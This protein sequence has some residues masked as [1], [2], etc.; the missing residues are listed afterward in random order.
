VFCDSQ[1]PTAE[2]L[3]LGDLRYG[4]GG[5]VG[6]CSSIKPLMMMQLKHWTDNEPLRY[7]QLAQSTKAV[8]NR[9]SMQGAKRYCQ[10][11]GMFQV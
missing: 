7:S 2:G 4:A 1:R 3:P 8:N 11:A 9:E 10:G 5:G 6:R